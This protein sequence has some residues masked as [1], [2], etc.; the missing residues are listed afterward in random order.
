MDVDFHKYTI[1][2]VIL[3]I[4]YQV[5]GDGWLSSGKWEAKFGRWLAKFSEMRG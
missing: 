4:C 2:S 1:D 3:E 5:Q